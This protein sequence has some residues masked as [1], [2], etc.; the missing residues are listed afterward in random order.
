LRLALFD[1]DGTITTR[2]SLLDFIRY[3][4]GDLRTT[5]GMVSL[6]PMLVAYRLGVIPNDRAKARM[7]AHF[8]RGMEIES[9]REV[10]KAYAQTQIDAI[11]RPQALKRI[12]WHL[13][14]GDRVVV[15]SASIRCWLA[16]WCEAQGVE[17]LSTEMEVHAGVLTGRFLTP[18]C[19]GPQKVVR[20]RGLLDPKAYDKIY[21]YG[22][23]SG[24]RELLALADEP[25]YRP[26]RS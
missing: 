20:L 26:F 17:L 10:A 19:H 2:D 8:F 15:V 1:F 7:L 12:A 22:D 6:A 24:D 23:S 9:F 21:A 11:V 25:F 18:N 3:A 13:S 16:P 4:V 5:W 14:Q